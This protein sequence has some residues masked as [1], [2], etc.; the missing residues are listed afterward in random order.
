MVSSGKGCDYAARILL[1]SLMTCINCFEGGRADHFGEGLEIVYRIG[2]VVGGHF[3][4]NFRRE[5]AC[6]GTFAFLGLRGNSLCYYVG[7]WDDIFSNY[8]DNRLNGKT[9][10]TKVN[11]ME[12]LLPSEII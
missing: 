3:R 12:L 2:G 6:F 11:A 8:T 7:G 4:S 1:E 9:V 5:I 10:I